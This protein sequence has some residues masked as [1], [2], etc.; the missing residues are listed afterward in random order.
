MN[1]A[2]AEATKTPAVYLTAIFYVLLLPVM[3]FAAGGQFSFEAKVGK[4]PTGTMDSRVTHMESD[5]ETNERILENLVI[6]P[7]IAGCLLLSFRSIRRSAMKMREFLLMSAWAFL[8][9]LWSQEPIASARNSVYLL[10]NLGFAI[11][12]SKRFPRER[13]LQFVT[14]MG[15]IIVVA[16]CLV[17]VALPRYGVSQTFGGVA[18]WQGFISHKN[19]CSYMTV[20]LLSPAF[21]MEK[22]SVGNRVF[23]AVY[24]I[25][26]VGVVYM[27]QSRTGWVVL[28]LALAFTAILRVVRRI[29]T[30]DTAVVLLGAGACLVALAAAT[31]GYL[32][33]LLN[34]LGKDSSLNGR[35]EIWWAV[36]QSIVKRP[37]TGYGFHA[38]WRGLSGES[39]NVTAN[40]RWGVS[41]AHNGI[42]EVWCELGI[43]GVGLVVWSFVRACKNAA[44]CLRAKSPRFVEWYVL[45]IFLTV[46]VNI[47][48]DTLLATA[49]F[50][51]TLYIIA[52]EGLA[53]EAR[54]LRLARKQHAEEIP[55]PC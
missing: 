35:T 10:I 52:C 13:I 53:V 8:S 1:N 34:I 30:A 29:G 18:S 44:L 48:E 24:F 55:A 32:P 43:V 7:I 12:L 21:F 2:V 25:L 50:G 16:N 19:L 36:F 31:V 5:E 54:S 45:I 28:I 33:A 4:S 14:C 6:Y 46:I 9:I 17:S 41:F 40:L 49:Q 22:R 47:G 27:T 39:A 37:L 51:W 42:L 15:A 26:S 38:F 3:Y 23:M 20:F 11:Y